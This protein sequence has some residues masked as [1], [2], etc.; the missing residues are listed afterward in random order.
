MRTPSRL[1]LVGERL[2]AALEK[3]AQADPDWLQGGHRAGQA[4]GADLRG[5]LGERGVADVVELVLNLPVPTDPGGDLGSRG[6]GAGRK[7]VTKYRRWTVVFRLVR[8]VG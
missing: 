1:E 5:V 7:L 6:G 2:R 4:A 3:L 8:S